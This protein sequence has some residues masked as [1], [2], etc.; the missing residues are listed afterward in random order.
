[1]LSVMMWDHQQAKREF[2]FKASPPAISGISIVQI[3]KQQVPM[4]LP[5]QAVN[6]PVQSTQ[7]KYLK[8]NRQSMF[9]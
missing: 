7:Q 1:M 9:C 8:S 2:S 5:P 3:D 4:E 6:Q